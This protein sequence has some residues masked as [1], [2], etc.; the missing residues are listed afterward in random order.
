MEIAES[1]V[2]SFLEILPKGSTILEIGTGGGT[3]LLVEHY[4]VVSVDDKTKYHTGSSELL[5]VPLIAPDVESK[6]FAWR[7]P[8]ATMWYDPELLKSKLEGRTYDALLIDGP[9]GGRTRAWMWY[10]YDKIF[11]T[12]VPVIVDDV[13]RQYE[14]KVALKI[15]TVKSQPQI[16]VRDANIR[17]SFAI[18]V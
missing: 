2:D 5:H 12:S 3:E 7:F 10:F 13:H 8:D 18:I 6:S 15:A 1:V 16:I 11:D 17:N 14:W 4:S 9:P